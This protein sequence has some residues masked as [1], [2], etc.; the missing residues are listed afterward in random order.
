MRSLLQLKFEY[1]WI[2]SNWFAGLL[3]PVKFSWSFRWASIV[4]A[5]HLDVRYRPRLPGATRTRPLRLALACRL[6]QFRWLRF[7]SAG[8]ACRASSLSSS[9]AS[10]PGSSCLLLHKG[11]TGTR[12]DPVAGPDPVTSATAA[13]VAPLGG[14]PLRRLVGGGCGSTSLRWCCCGGGWCDWWCCW[15]PRLPLCDIFHWC[16]LDICVFLLRLVPC[17]LCLV[18]VRERVLCC[19]T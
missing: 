11:R 17:P 13:V 16:W 19:K 4:D 9:P 8:S 7:A 12:S 14:L 1:Y 2:V 10:A 3:I 18:L 15:L 5:R 6:C